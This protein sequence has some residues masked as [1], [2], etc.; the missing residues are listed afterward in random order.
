MA[1]LLKG[2]TVPVPAPHDA[3]PSNPVHGWA[4]MGLCA[5]DAMVTDLVTVGPE[6]TVESAARLMVERNVGSVLVVD[7]SAR[8]QGILTEGDF[9]GKKGGLPLSGRTMAYLFGETVGL[10]A[11]ADIY[12][13]AAP[14]PV[15]EFMTR[16]VEVVSPTT[17]LEDVVNLMVDRE[18]K[19]I[20]VVEAGRLVGIVARRDVLRLMGTR[21]K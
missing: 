8:I 13:H 5:R 17:P 21:P 2:P 1:T 19:R 4:T 12:R 20:P 11:L 15:K 9:I 3:K 16:E 7:G 10:E 14:R 18:V 6:M